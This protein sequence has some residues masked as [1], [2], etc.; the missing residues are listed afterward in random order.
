M[1]L[2]DRRWLEALHEVAVEVVEGLGRQ[3]IQGHAAERGLELV[4]DDVVVALDGGGRSAG[5]LG[6]RQPLVKQ[7]PE[8][9]RRVDGTGPAGLDLLDQAAQRPL[10]FRPGASHGQRPLSVLPRV[11][12]SAER[13]PQL[14]DPAG[15]LGRD[16]S[17][18]RPLDPLRRFETQEVR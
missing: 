15:N 4:I 2:Q 7:R 8:G 12:V 13:H 1:N 17:S 11:R 16:V 6:E 3:S 10:R 18:H 9:E 14:V 5:C